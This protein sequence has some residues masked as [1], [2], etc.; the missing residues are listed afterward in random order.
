[1]VERLAAMTTV[2]V[3]PQPPEIE[4][5][6]HCHTPYEC[7][8]WA[9]CT[10]EKPH[11]WIYHLPGKKE[12]VTQLVQQGITT[13]DDIPDEIRLSDVQ[14]KVKDNVEWVSGRLAA[15]LRTVT[16]PVHHLDFE[17]FSPALPRYPRTRPYQAIPIQW[18]NH[19]EDR[20]GN[21]IHHEFLHGD[22]SDP[23]RPL[24]EALLDSLGEAGSICVYSPYEK[25]VIEQLAE[26]FP[27][28]RLELRNLVKRI[29]DLHPIVKGHYYHPEFRGSFSLKEVLPALA[30]LL[31]YD[32]LTI[33]EGGHAA[34]EYYRMIFIETDWVERDSIREALLRYCA[35]DTLAMVELRRVLKEKADRKF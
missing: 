35:R 16:F 7:P 11:R 3:Q 33:R 23:R 26:A 29:W 13:I 20:E 1:V 27:E 22:M 28:F 6:Q 25:S 2:V 14:R 19:I 31:R 17:T 5:D 12:I 32:D 24:V 34:A 9:H 8:F 21:I 10:K 4:P 30:P 15:E 18:S